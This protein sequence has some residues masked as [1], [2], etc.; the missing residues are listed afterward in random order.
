MP[1][2]IGLSNPFGGGGF[3]KAGKQRATILI[4]LMD[5]EQVAAEVLEFIL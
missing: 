3:A 2:V 4:Q 1:S 5:M